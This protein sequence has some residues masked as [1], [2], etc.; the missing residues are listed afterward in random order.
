MQAG[1]VVIPSRLSLNM[2]LWSTQAAIIWERK[3]IIRPVLF[4]LVV[5][6]RR[7]TNGATHLPNLATHLTNLATHLPNSG[8]TQIGTQ[9]I[10]MKGSFL[11]RFVVPVQGIFF[12]ALAA[13]ADGPVKKNFSLNVHYFTSYASWAGSHTES[14]VS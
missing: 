14:P 3:A 1:Q 6:N 10:H 13:A 9:G 4:C 5:A 11:G 8:F 7:S 2:C 12:P